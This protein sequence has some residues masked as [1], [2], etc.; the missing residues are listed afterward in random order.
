[1]RNLISNTMA[2]LVGALDAGTLGKV[3]DWT[4]LDIVY[5]EPR[6]R[7]LWKQVD[8]WRIY[9]HEIFPTDKPYYHPHPWASAMYLARGVYTMGVGYGDP[10]GPPPPLATTLILQTGTFYD[11]PDPKGWHF[12]APVRGPAYT[13]M[14]TEKPWEHGKALAPKDVPAAAPLP[15]E[16]KVALW[17][18]F[19][20]IL[21]GLG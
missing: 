18:V 11:M 14:V 16:E 6:V 17:N 10:F 5:E 8:D 7:R 3:D 2:K 20:E 1:M 19:N 12:V 4:G 21:K 9:L 13:V 15:P